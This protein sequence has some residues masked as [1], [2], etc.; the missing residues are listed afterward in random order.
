MRRWWIDRGD[1]RYWLEVTDRSDV[2]TNLKAPQRNESGGEFWSYSLVLEVEP[3]DFVFHYDRPSQRIMGV[4]HATG[5]TWDDHIVWGARGTYAREAGV[6]PHR[7]AG[8]YAGLTGFRS[9][10]RPVSLGDI[11]EKAPEIQEGLDRLASEVGGPLYFPFERGETRPIR[12]LQ[13]Y[14]FRLPR[15]FVSLF[16]ELGPER[17]KRRRDMQAIVVRESVGEEYRPADEEASVAGFDP[18]EVDP[19]IVERAT[20]GHALTQN[21]AANFLRTRGILPRS[22]SSGEPDFDL[23][24]EADE[25]VFVAE[26]KSITN[27]NEERQLRMGIGQVLQYRYQ[28]GQLLEREVVA[29]IVAEREPPAFWISFCDS[30]GVRVAWPGALDRLLP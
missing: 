24:W 11:R 17:P 26:V 10:A 22:P 25:V 14:L 29:A 4:S 23:A 20:R 16:P 7:R 21:V 30:L 9:L 13:G 18:L 3:G 2:G 19:A 5:D 28:L 27:R 6:T 8:W 15:F 12:P 1:E